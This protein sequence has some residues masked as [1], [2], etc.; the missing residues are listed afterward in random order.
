M[1]KILLVEDEPTINRMI[2]NYLVKEGYDVYKTFDGLGAIDAIKKHTFNLVCLDIMLPKMSGWEIAKHLREKSN[3]PIIMMSAL[4]DEEDILKGYDLKVDDYITKPF[5]PRVLVAKIN[6][7]LAR[8]SDE[9]TVPNHLIQVPH[10]D[11][12]TKRKVIALDGRELSLAR[13]EFELLTFLIQHP[14]EICSREFLFES[15]WGKDVDGDPRLVDT[16]VKK[17][18][19]HLNDYADFIKTIFGVGYRF[20]AHD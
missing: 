2:Y 16:Y 14:N 18:R 20:E 12:D 9:K 17:L 6:A 15:V 1:K 3:V 10:L 7:L 11:V 5:N 19:K 4:S 13:K 8:F